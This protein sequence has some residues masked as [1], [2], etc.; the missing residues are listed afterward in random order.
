[1]E[2]FITGQ[3]SDSIPPIMD[4]VAIVADNYAF[5]LN[6]KYGE[7][8]LVGPS[9]GRHADDPG[10]YLRFPSLSIPG[11]YPYRIGL[12]H[13]D[14]SLFRRLRKIPFSLVHS[15][16][17]FIAG[18]IARR[19]ARIHGIPLAATF[20]SK[21]REDI[22]KHVQAKLI[23]DALMDHIV[24]YYEAA[25]MVF[26]PNRGTADILREYGYHGEIEVIPNG[27]ELIPPTEAERKAQADAARA[28]FGMKFP[29]FTMLFVGQHRW[30][31]NTRLIIEALS[32]LKKQYRKQFLMVFVGTGPEAADMK[33]LVKEL[34]LTE[35][36]RFLGQVTDRKVLTSFY[37]ATDL[38]I[39]PSLYDNASIAVREASA[40]R[41]PSIMVEES[42][43]AQGIRDCENGFLIKNNAA[44]CAEKIARVMDNPKLLHTAGKKAQE[45]IY[46]H[47]E[48]VVDEL[49][50][51]YRDLVSRT[52]RTTHP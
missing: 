46:M 32:L 52:S 22:A 31:K 7:S 11:S 37:A 47:W 1:M 48:Q 25:D 26:T 15:H 18:D 29:L 34:H 20:H 17:P 10:Y 33:R 21:Y 51:R 19:T 5:W 24:H 41:V 16:N 14:P 12:A 38:F 23:A 30:E 2:R 50:L 4:G 8:F 9:S 43:T 3:F 45:S 13:V 44:S 39:F 40:Y 28:R 36:V 27:T 42:T 6:Q 49:V 35:E